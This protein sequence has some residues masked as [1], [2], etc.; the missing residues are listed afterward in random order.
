MIAHLL[1]SH[2]IPF[3]YEKP[4]A[5]RDGDKT[6][7]WHPDFTLSSGLIIE[8]SGMEHDRAYLRRMN[9]KLR[10]YRQNQFN[11]IVLSPKTMTRW[12]KLNLMD[13]IA[14][15]LKRHY[16]DFCRRTRR[17]PIV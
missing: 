10:I 16:H 5:V 13:L 7:I 11:V 1:R 8:Y 3:I 15:H 6:K 12:W 2:S 9:H 14:S 17:G 4:T